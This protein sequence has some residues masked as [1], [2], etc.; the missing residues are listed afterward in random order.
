MRPELPTI[1]QKTAGVR[2][3]PLAAL[4]NAG[5]VTLTHTPSPM[6]FLSEVL[7]RPKHERAHILIATGYPAEDAQVPSISRRPL[8]EIATFLELSCP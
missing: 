7:E 5:L 8:D 3:F 2:G 4:H 1:W 6:G